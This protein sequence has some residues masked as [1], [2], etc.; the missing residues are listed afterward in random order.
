[1]EQKVKNKVLIISGPTGSGETTITTEI[2]EKYP[3]FQRLVAATSRPI[4]SGEEEQIN[5]Y[6]LG[7]EKFLEEIENENII[8]YTYIQNRDTYYGT[9]KPDLEKKIK[10]SHVIA[11]VDYVGVKYFKENYDA[12][13]I[14]IKPSSLEVIENRLRTRN[15][16]TTDQEI[17]RRLKNAEDEI[18]SEQHLYDFVVINDDGKL[19]EAV[20]EVRKILKSKSYIQ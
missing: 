7:K 1:M 3:C 5:Y 9:Y 8:E 14:F 20:E 19:N 6:Y 16:E 13:A 18:N 12:L 4:R 17:K 15:P 2:I 11:N 10:D